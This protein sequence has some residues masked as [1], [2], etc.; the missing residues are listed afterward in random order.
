VTAL[1]LR[2]DARRLPLPDASVDLIVTS[3]P[4][5]ALRSYT[6]GGQ[7][8]AGQIGS[9]PTPAEYIAALVECTR[10]WVRVLKP[11]GSIFVNLGD[12]YSAYGGAHKG[13][14]RDLEG[15]TRDD[16]RG[17]PQA[18]GYR[19]P[20]RWGVPAK[21]LMLLPERYRIACVDQ[22]DLIARAVI[23]W[24]KP[25]GLPESVTDRVRRSHEDWVHLTRSPRYFAAVDE[26]R[27]PHAARTY[28]QH[29]IDVRAGL[30]M[31]I[32]GHRGAS[33]EGLR[34]RSSTPLPNPLGKLPG[35]VWEVATEP[36]QVPAGVDV[37]HFA[38]FPSEWPRRLILGWSPSGVCTACGE[39]RRPVGSVPAGSAEEL[40][41][42]IKAAREREGMT[43]AELAESIGCG[44]NNVWDYEVGGHLPT[45]ATWDRL[46]AVLKLEADRARF[47]A[48]RTYLSGTQTRGRRDVRVEGR[49]RTHIRMGDGILVTIT[50]YACACPEPTA[51]TRP[52]VVLD[53]FGGTGTTA[54][55]AAA[56]GRIGIT[57]DLSLDYSRL[58]ANPELADRRRRKVLG[59]AR[60]VTALIPT[61]QTSLDFETT[62]D[63]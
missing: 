40:G 62:D 52:A 4:Y 39:G 1:A 12:K 2:G 9:E 60:T 57:V 34:Q 50:G 21:S 53:P 14:G 29:L 17:G 19:D 20:D 42:V 32:S 56:L 63:D 28:E 31:S 61:G 47:I 41:G 30:G 59:L 7:H 36:L 38:A 3:P 54:H 10:E 15:H 11:S 43:R 55:V 13:H 6:D 33:Q 16:H 35:S 18:L 48:E 27:E 22:L 23:V 46:S 49:H 5:F 44:S 51:P 26:I 58:A 8:Y 24:A 37:D 45:G 25:N